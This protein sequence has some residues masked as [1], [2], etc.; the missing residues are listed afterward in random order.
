MKKL[1]VRCLGEGSK[2]EKVWVRAE[3]NCR[4]IERRV[5][6][7]DRSC[8]SKLSVSVF[9]KLIPMPDHCNL[10]SKNC[11]FTFSV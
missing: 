5:N 7:R 2:G 4:K 10:L 9:A 6:T 8:V 3:K 11:C 1:T